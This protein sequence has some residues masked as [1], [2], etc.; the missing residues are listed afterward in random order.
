MIRGYHYTD[1]LNS[2]LEHGL[3]RKFAR[4]ETYGEPNMIWFSTVLPQP[5][6]DYVEVHL[7]P[8]EVNLNGPDLY[9]KNYH[10]DPP[11]DKT[12]EELDA[13]VADYNAGQHNFA[14]YADHIPP[15]RIVTHSSSWMHQARY[16][17]KE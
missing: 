16:V 5:G 17:E 3:D 12:R 15:A 11:R 8:Y 1:N 10:A 9:P 13:E 7:S 14:S 2:V 4:G 6:K